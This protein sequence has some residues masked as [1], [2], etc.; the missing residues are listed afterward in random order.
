MSLSCSCGDY[1]PEPGDVTWWPPEDF[2]VLTTKRSRPCHSCGSRIQPGSVCT[3]TIR[4]KTPESE[5]EIRIYGEDSDDR[6]PPRA[7]WWMCEACSDIYF[8]LDELGYCVEMGDMHQLLTEYQEQKQ[9]ERE[10]RRKAV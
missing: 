7:S 5:I 6:G 2:T 3:E 9:W 10:Q 8:S 4:V 1:E